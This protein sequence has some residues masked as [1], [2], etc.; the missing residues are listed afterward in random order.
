MQLPVGISAFADWLG[1]KFKEGGTAAVGK[2]AT[3]A[4]SGAV[5]AGGAAHVGAGAGAA[6]SGVGGAVLIGGFG[7]VSAIVNQIEF[8]AA[9]DKIAR[10]YDEELAAKLGKT[11]KKIGGSDVGVLET[12]DVKKHIAENN[13]IKEALRRER[14]IRN[15]GIAASFIASIAT[16]TLMGAIVGHPPLAIDW[17]TA[18]RITVSVLTYMALKVPVVELAKTMFGLN[19]E[20]THD[21]IIEIAKDRRQGK[22][23][24]RE[25][26]VEVFVSGNKDLAAYVEDH[27]GKE[28]E[29][30]SLADK[31]NV[32]EQLSALLPIDTI[33]A[34]INAGTT[35]ASELAFTVDGQV[36]GVLPKA[37]EKNESRS[38]IDA[39]KHKCQHMANKVGAI[40]RP[41]KA[42]DIA[43]MNMQSDSAKHAP[44]QH[45][46]LADH[47]RTDHAARVG[48]APPE[49]SA[50]QVDRLAQARAAQITA[51]TS[52]TVH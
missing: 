45:Q 18:A 27:F 31:V 3:E 39:F 25:Q 9:K 6:F 30:L 14:T 12:G 2:P 8:N 22:S 29:K 10:F 44:N 46:Y 23:V 13:T 16:F 21:K 20:T 7:A 43:S 36:S 33:T 34:N 47:T 52:Q 50:S 24:T 26:V 15:V 32:A 49:M 17:G 48:R 5:A 41:E 37:P 40:F 28:Y 51:P 19:K 4:A 1:L 35:N 42:D 11:A 38:M